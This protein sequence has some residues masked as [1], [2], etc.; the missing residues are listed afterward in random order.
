[1]T[2]SPQTHPAVPGSI[3]KLATAANTVE[4]FTG[5]GM[6]AES[7]LETFRDKQTGLWSKVDPIA[8]ANFDAWRRDPSRIWPWYLWR[9]SKVQ[10]ATPNAGHIAIAKWT[11]LLSDGPGWGHVTT[12]N[13]DN[14][15]ERAGSDH[16]AHLHGSL[17]AF[18]CDHCGAP[19]EQPDPPREPVEKLMPPFCE[20]CVAGL[21]RPG[22]VWFGESLPQA[23]WME[24]EMYSQKAELMIVT[25]TSGV[26]FPAAGLP[27]AAVEAGIPVVE[28]SPEET[29]FTPHA[30]HF[31]QTTAAVGLPALV[32]VVKK[33]R[34]Q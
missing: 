26:V 1:M 23:A 15:H 12:Q 3:A 7:G 32:D 25:G 19:A 21:I 31:W 17:F 20:R 2:T 33:A 27:L 16:V 18:R 8:M 22:V 6:S 10:N 11:E 30:T 29:D 9:M 24:A 5:A 34:E 14:L 28:I 4:F 13:I